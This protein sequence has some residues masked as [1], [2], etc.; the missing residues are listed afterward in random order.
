MTTC[1]VF[2]TQR[3]GGG[4]LVGCGGGGG[5]RR[6]EPG[7]TSRSESMEMLSIACRCWEQM[8]LDMISLRSLART[9][10]SRGAA[11]PLVS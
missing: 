1:G 4:A 7:K 8:N 10:S 5:R 3:E 11:G 6:R 9:K 2:G